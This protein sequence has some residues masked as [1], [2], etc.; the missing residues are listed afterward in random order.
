MKHEEKPIM[1][2]QTE[3]PKTIT[4]LGIECSHDEAFEDS[5]IYT[6]DPTD[7]EPIVLWGS[8]MSGLYEGWYG[9]VSLKVA[10]QPDYI[11]LLTS[12]IHTLFPTIEVLDS[13]LKEVVQK[14]QELIGSLCNGE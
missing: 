13:Y 1:V 4:L 14:Y 8:Y 11:D 5:V 10:D 12:N 9:G 2:G 3:L 7:T 6:N